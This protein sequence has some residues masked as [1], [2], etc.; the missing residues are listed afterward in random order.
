MNIYGGMIDMA[1]GATKV[2]G[3][4]GGSTNEDQSRGGYG[5]SL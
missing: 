1:D 3:S 2:K 4:L 5:I